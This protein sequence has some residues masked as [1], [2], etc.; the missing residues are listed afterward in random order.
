MIEDQVG[1]PLY[2][3]YSPAVVSCL[4]GE[5]P[6]VNPKGPAEAALRHA[7]G[8]AQVVVCLEPTVRYRSLRVHLIP[9]LGSASL[10]EHRT[11]FKSS[12]T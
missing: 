1:K 11:A 3:E 8:H 4:L 6:A 12:V 2:A 10:L 7:A 5:V 9:S